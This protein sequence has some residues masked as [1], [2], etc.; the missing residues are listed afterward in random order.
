MTHQE[1]ILD[2]LQAQ[3]E[4]LQA[5]GS[6]FLEHKVLVSQA[7]RWSALLDLEQACLFALERQVS[8]GYRQNAELQA[9]KE[10]VMSDVEVIRAQIEGENAEH[11]RSLC[12]LRE[13]L[14]V[15]QQG[16]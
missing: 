7:S 15:L 8:S 1:A 2:A 14:Q 12:R 16:S 3:R 9:E 11:R 10:E 5:S 4:L 6:R 13:K